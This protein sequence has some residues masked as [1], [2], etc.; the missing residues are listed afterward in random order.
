MPRRPLPKLQAPIDTRAA[1]NDVTSTD[2]V[3]TNKKLR[4]SGVSG[5]VR[6][7]RHFLDDDSSDAIPSAR[8]KPRKRAKN[9]SI[10]LCPD[11]QRD[12]AEQQRKASEREQ[13]SK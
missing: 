12:V 6:F 4:K 1:L 8:G 5:Y 13:N 10:L 11:A 9:G 2:T 7:G 3:Q